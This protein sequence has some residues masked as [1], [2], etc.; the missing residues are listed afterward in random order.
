MTPT[1]PGGLDAT[2]FYGHAYSNWDLNL[3]PPLL[4]A[5][6][7]AVADLDA[8]DDGT[9]ELDR[10]RLSDLYEGH[11][12]PGSPVLKDVNIGF[13]GAM[14]LH[15]HAFPTFDLTLPRASIVYNGER[16]GVW[17]KAFDDGIGPNPWENSP[18]V[19]EVRPNDVLEGHIFADGDF[20]LKFTSHLD[21]SEVGGGLT[22]GFTIEDSGIS[23][24]STE[25]WSGRRT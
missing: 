8:N 4:S 17:L 3:V 25:L 18:S 23:W 22:F 19:L 15:Y 13:D 10:S 21:F 1:T 20:L 6:G 9:I 12:S 2:H 24:T 16:D 14:V 7:A 5:K 11:I